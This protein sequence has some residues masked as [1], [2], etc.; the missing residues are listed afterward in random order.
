MKK[1]KNMINITCISAIIL[2]VT[3]SISPS[4][5][6]IRIPDPLPDIDGHGCP[7]SEADDIEKDNNGNKVIDMSD[8]LRLG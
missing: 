7:H 1:S 2:L 8:V 5:S 3:L 6:V 4:I